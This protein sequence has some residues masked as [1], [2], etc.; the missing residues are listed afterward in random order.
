MRFIS[1][2]D[3]CRLAA[4][5]GLGFSILSDDIQ[6]LWQIG[7]LRADLVVSDKP[8]EIP[9]LVGLRNDDEGNY[10]YADERTCLT[11][12]NGLTRSNP[13]LKESH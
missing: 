9:G 10:L 2:N 5:R 8:L 6:R 12:S 7:M 3:L 4:E 11:T 1:A 13:C